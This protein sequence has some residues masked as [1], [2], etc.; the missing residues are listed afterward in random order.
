MLTTNLEVYAF[1]K[2]HLLAQAAPAKNAHAPQ[3]RS[4]S[5]LKCAIGCLISDEHYDARLEGQSVQS[6]VIQ[7]AVTQSLGFEPDFSMLT[8]LQRI[9]DSYPVSHWAGMLA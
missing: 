8:R 6:A 1:V 9:H 5:G 4:D 3:Y 2:A 7:S